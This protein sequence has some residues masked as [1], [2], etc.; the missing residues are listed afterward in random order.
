MN[1]NTIAIWGFLILS[2]LGIFFGFRTKLLDPID[3]LSNLVTTEATATKV[4][5]R[6]YAKSREFAGSDVTYAFKVDGKSYI[7]NSPVDDRVSV[8]QK[9][10]VQ[11]H[12]KNPGLSGMEL[13][14]HALFDLFIFAVPLVVFLVCALVLIL[15]L[16]Q[17]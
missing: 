5:E 11:Y 9:V 10:N 3:R 17:K 6:V 12:A 4:K 8:G 13:R 7:G 15:R 1:N 2:G 16:K 14:G